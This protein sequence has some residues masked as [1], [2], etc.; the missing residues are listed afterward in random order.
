MNSIK[1]NNELLHNFT[2]HQDED[3]FPKSLFK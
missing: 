1:Q 2:H 3:F